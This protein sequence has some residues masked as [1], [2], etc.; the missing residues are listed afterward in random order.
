MYVVKYPAAMLA[1]VG[2]SI[3]IDG[4]IRHAESGF[5]STLGTFYC[6]TFNITLM[7]HRINA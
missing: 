7:C 3:L 2:L 4:I 1:A 5:F 6:V